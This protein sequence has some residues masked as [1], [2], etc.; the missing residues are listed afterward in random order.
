MDY[1]HLNSLNNQGKHEEFVQQLEIIEKKEKYELSKNEHLEMAYY[2]INALFDLSRQKEISDYLEIVK[3]KFENDVSKETL[4][5]L[6]VLENLSLSFLIFLE[7]ALK[8]STKAEK[9]VTEL[10]EIKEP[11]IINWIGRYYFAYGILLHRKG[12]HS[13]AIDQFI[14]SLP[15]FEASASSVEVVWTLINIGAS[16]IIIGK[17]NKASEYLDRGLS[18]ARSLGNKHSI[19]KIF[20]LKSIIFFD[21]GEFT[22]GIEY[23]Q[24]GLSL[25]RELKDKNSIAIVLLNLGELYE[26]KGDLEG[27]LS[28]YQE[29]LELFNEIE[30]I[31]FIGT[32][33]GRIGSVYRLKGAIQQAK[34]NYLHSLKIFETEKTQD[35]YVGAYKHVPLF[36]LIQISLDQQDLNQAQKF[37]ETFRHLR[38]QVSHYETGSYF[39]LAEILVLKSDDRLIKKA[40]AQKLLTE[41]V[42]EPIK[43]F[44]VT[45]LAITH[46]CELLLEEFKLYEKMKVLEEIRDLLK[47]L[48]NLSQKSHSY[49]VMVNALLIQAKFA[50]IE[51]K[52]SDASDLLEKAKK[53]S[54]EKDLTLLK[55]QVSVETKKIKVNFK[56]MEELIAINATFKEKIEK[57]ELM[58]YIKNAQKI[59][60]EKKMESN[61]F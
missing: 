42:K 32:V 38:D 14:Q 16:Y 24:E 61:I 57:S 10:K 48:Y 1:L 18:V 26:T 7:K 60:I 5:A 15:M 30:Q 9:I 56:K 44:Q 41:L 25:F 59:V 21:N 58:D 33:Y 53:L 37:L 2:K 34:E 49:S 40:E 27:A 43:V 36:G 12:Q 3:A 11:S 55:E 8:I 52:F 47:K 50:V 13:E 46:L 39:R 45:T 28:Y 22:K 19:G 35:Q 20:T 6:L 17:K 29:A 23:A 4:L 54:A 31:N 51:E